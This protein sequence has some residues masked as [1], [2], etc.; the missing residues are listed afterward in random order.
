MFADAIETVSNFT[1]PIHSIRRNYGST[2]IQ[3]SAA[4]LFFVN[5]EGWALTC[6]HVAE[7]LMA[8]DTLAAK[9]KQFDAEVARSVGVRN[10]EQLRRELEARYQYDAQAPYEIHNRF[11][12]CADDFKTI[13]I[14][15]HPE[16]D[17]ALLQFVGFRQLACNVFPTFPAPNARLRQ[18][19]FLCRLGFPFP[20]FTNFQYVSEN[21]VIAWTDAGRIASPSFPLE[22]MV[23]RLVA[24]ETLRVTGFELST[25]GLRGQSGGPVF[26]PQ[27]VVWGMQQA[28]M[29][30]DMDFD[31]DQ[32]VMRSGVPKRVADSAFL[33][34]GRCVHFSALTA[35]MDQ[36]HVRYTVAKPSGRAW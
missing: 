6:R 14:T 20:E 7:L 22:G 31:V 32:A 26:D 11:I 16:I 25:P 4:T 13:N 12:S 18:G 19:Q 28:T 3:P 34:V 33:H 24:D 23:T 1:R 27:G 36:N 15:W 35:F 5:D 8:S 17:L 10:R 2:T 21:D 30:L 29:H 9:R